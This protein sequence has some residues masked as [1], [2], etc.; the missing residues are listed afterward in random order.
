MEKE[1]YAEF[2]NEE[3]EELV[4]YCGGDTKK[5]IKWWNKNY[6]TPSTLEELMNYSKGDTIEWSSFPS[7]LDRWRNYMYDYE[8][9]L[10]TSLGE[11]VNMF[12]EDLDEDELKEV[13]DKENNAYIFD[14]LE[15]KMNE[16][17]PGIVKFLIDNKVSEI[18]FTW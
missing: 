6:S 12:C 3:L 14:K 13:W 7:D 9:G 16:Y 18:I 2:D 1:F 17:C 5:V 11:T 15:E 4:K 8:K 10:E